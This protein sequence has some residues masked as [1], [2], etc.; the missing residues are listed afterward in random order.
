MLELGKLQTLEV[1]KEKDFGVY[2]YYAKLHDI[3]QPLISDGAKDLLLRIQLSQLEIEYQPISKN[4]LT[5]Y[6]DEFK[7]PNTK[8]FIQVSSLDSIINF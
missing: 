6:I 2:E 3:F 8:E 4:Y 5:I 7:K 1:I